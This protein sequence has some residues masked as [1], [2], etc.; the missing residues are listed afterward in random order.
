MATIEV[1]K[2]WTAGRVNRPVAPPQPPI[3]AMI[4]VKALTILNVGKGHYMPGETFVVTPGLADDLVADGLV[5]VVKKGVDVP[6]EA[7]ADDGQYAEEPATDLATDLTRTK[8]AAEVPI[9][10]AVSAISEKQAEADNGDIDEAEETRLKQL[11]EGKTGQK[12]DKAVG[13]RQTKEDKGAAAA[14]TK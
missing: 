5:E 1:V 6:K 9:E 10:E 7:R 8:Q 12:E 11:N 13:T 4:E 2:S 3:I 14:Q